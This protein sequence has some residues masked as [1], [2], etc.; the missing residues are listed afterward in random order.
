MV[1][2]T[3]LTLVKQLVATPYHQRKRRGCLHLCEVGLLTI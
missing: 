3:K 2:E 1:A